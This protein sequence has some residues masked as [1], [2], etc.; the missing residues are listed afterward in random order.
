MEK[1]AQCPLTPRTTARRRKDTEEEE[2][3]GEGNTGQM[4]KKRRKRRGRGFALE[5]VHKQMSDPSKTN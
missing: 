1:V 4:T 5:S 2:E 3:A